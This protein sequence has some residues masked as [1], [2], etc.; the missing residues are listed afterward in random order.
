MESF[1]DGDA[2]AEPDVPAPERIRLKN[3]DM[4]KAAATPRKRCQE[5]ARQL[6]GL[7]F[8]PQDKSV[9]TKASARGPRYFLA[10]GGEG[11]IETVDNV[12]KEGVFDNN[13]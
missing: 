4:T 8:Q 1:F 10:G 9:S 7:S 12:A 13:T 2:V 6:C 11:I 5:K 3:E